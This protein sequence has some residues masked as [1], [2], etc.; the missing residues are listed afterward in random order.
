MRL[1]RVLRDARERLVE[2]P[3]VGRVALAFSLFAFAASLWDLPSSFG[4]ENDGI[5][6]R[7]LFGGF[8]Y[9]L[10]PGSAHR[11][12]LFHYLLVGLGSLPALLL[13]LLSGWDF[14]AIA[15][16]ERV[17]SV[18]CMTAVSL[19]AKL[20][21]IAMSA[22]TLATAA[23]IAR[24]THSELAGRFTALCLAVM[25]SFS[26]YA[27]TTNLDAPYLFWS[28]LAQDRLLDCAERPTRRNYALFGVLLAAAIA[29]K[30]QAYAGFV[31]TAPGYLAL[32][33]L[34]A[35][36]S[37]RRARYFGVFIAALAAVVT[38]ALLSGAAVNP[39]GFLGRVALL[40][41]PNSQDWR[42]YEPTFGGRVANLVD[43]WRVSGAHAWSAPLLALAGTGVVSAVVR[44]LCGRDARLVLL[45]LVYATSHMVFF[46]LLVG[47]TQHRFVLPVY[48]ALSIYAGAAAASLVTWR[49]SPDY[50]RAVSLVL[51]ALFAYDGLRVL[52]LAWVGYRDA[53][54]EVE[55][56]LE[57]AGPGAR[58][59]TYGL[60]VQQP[61]FD[62][63]SPTVTRV[64]PVSSPKKRNPIREVIEVEAP[65]GAVRE[66][67]P[68]VIVVPVYFAE[69]FFEREPGAGRMT[70]RERARAQADA[71]ARRYFERIFS[72]DLPGYR[73][74]EVRPRV[75]EWLARLVPYEVHGSVGGT[76][77]YL[78]RE[79]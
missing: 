42:Q 40:S 11:Y 39:T 52:A 12:P 35:P 70:S 25:I 31:L 46:T 9:N 5:A 15:I 22:L 26:Y 17:L 53:R 32:F 14:S 51:A 41:G 57:R 60:T 76:Y 16:R 66:R 10:K 49:P 2:D 56:L 20:L 18:P 44:R 23:R 3:V 72:D 8:A 33:A 4:W 64:D 7:D 79:R 74:R 30:D 27:R 69:R 73:A 6:P 61:R 71:D 65:Y 75:P 45:P 24:R 13:A 21:S 77:R 63:L 38:Y 1:R 58:V 47:R 37:E 48:A 50:R 54:R 68:D 29:T 19:V 59:E 36:A 43:L 62:R 67:D 55:A 78:E 34:R 28:F